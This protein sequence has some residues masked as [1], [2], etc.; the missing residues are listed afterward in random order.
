MFV[1]LVLCL[2]HEHVFVTWAYG[3]S[4]MSTCCLLHER[5]VFVT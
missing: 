5:V 4:Y 3:L 2:L 1:T